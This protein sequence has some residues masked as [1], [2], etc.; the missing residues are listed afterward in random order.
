MGGRQHEWADS[1]GPAGE[2]GA[3]VGGQQHQVDGEG[4]GQVEVVHDGEHDA[5][6]GKLHALPF[7]VRDHP[8]RI[9]RRP[10]CHLVRISLPLAVMR[11]R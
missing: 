9:A 11:R 1:R 8:A 2:D 4:G 5:G 10:R 3:A 6:L 7:I